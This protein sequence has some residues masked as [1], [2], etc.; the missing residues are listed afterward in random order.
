[1]KVIHAIGDADRL[2]VQTAVD[3]A[4]NHDTVVIGED[5]DL[6]VLLC[7]HSSTSSKKLFFRSDSRQSNTKCPKVWDLYKTKQLLGEDT[8]RILPFIHALTGCDTTSRIY[9]IGK[10]TALKAFIRNANLRETA[11]CFTKA[12]SK[13]EVSKLGQEALM[14]LF[15]GLPEDG[16]NLLRY[17][18]FARKVMASTTCIQVHSL[19]PTAAA[20]AYH[21]YRVYLQVQTWTGNDSLNPLDWGSEIVD[22]KLLPTKTDLPPAPEKLLHIIRCS[23]KTN[24]DSRRCSCRKHGLKCSVGCGD[25]RGIG[26]TN[27]YTLADVDMDDSD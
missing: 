6:L 20:A 17:R 23:C 16:L 2:I 22:N 14:Y 12:E 7:Y 21:I 5:T 25:C 8:C 1:M 19:P 27:S 24:C 11:E 4:N 13:E 26:C 3:S 9:G 18:T 15:G 10:G